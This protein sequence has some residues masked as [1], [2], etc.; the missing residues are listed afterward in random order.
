MYLWAHK[1]NALIS[2]LSMDEPVLW[3]FIERDN[4]SDVRAE[5]EAVRAQKD[6]ISSQIVDDKRRI[7][8]PQKYIIR[9]NAFF[10]RR[11]TN[12]ETISRK[13]WLKK[14]L[15]KHN[16]VRKPITKLCYNVLLPMETQPSSKLQ[17]YNQ[18]QKKKLNCGG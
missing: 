10:P 12:S 18:T 1:T 13:D 11:H 6:D 17:A 5:T 4:F 2:G 3:Y 14:G 7:Y 8:F 15:F 9:L 16:C